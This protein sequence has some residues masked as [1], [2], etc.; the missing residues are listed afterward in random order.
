[1]S[2]TAEVLGVVGGIFGILTGIFAMFVGTI[3]GIFEYGMITLALE[4][5]FNLGFGAVI[6]GIIGIV[7]GTIVNR[8]NKA[9]GALMLISGVV[10]FI[11]VSL[12]WVIAG[13]LLIVGG[14]LAFRKEYAWVWS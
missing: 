7:G 4:P 14:I 6:L 2:R 12:F 9:A 10:G 1:L 5:L 13:I 8:N 3:G 11:V